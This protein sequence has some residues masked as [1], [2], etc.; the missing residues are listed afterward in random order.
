MVGA[1]GWVVGARGG[2]RGR[3]G[4]GRLKIKKEEGGWGYA[5]VPQYPYTSPTKNFSLLTILTN[6][7]FH[8]V[9]SLT[10][11]ATA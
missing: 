2:G 8:D 11:K 7:P 9:I 5:V 4:G 3:E 10:Q 6:L 1:S